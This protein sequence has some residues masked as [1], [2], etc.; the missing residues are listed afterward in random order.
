MPHAFVLMPFDEG[1]TALYTDFI[2]PVLEEKGLTVARADDIES[3]RNILRDVIEGID[4]CDLVVAELTGNNPNVLYELGLAHALRKP[5]LHLTQNIDDVPF[6]LRSYRMI[7]Y[8][9]DFS[10]IGEAKE[11]LG[12]NARAF[13]DGRSSFGNPVTDF[14]VAPASRSVERD[15]TSLGTQ[16]SDQRSGEEHH[17]LAGSYREPRDQDVDLGF[18]DFWIAV[19]E[20]YGRAGEVAREVE[21][22]LVGLSDHMQ[23]ATDEFERLNANPNASTP[24]AAI[25]VCRRLAGRFQSFKVEVRKANGIFAETLDNTE[26]SLERLV[27]FQVEQCDSPDVIQELDGLRTIRDTV[28]STYRSVLGFADSMDRLPRVERRP[29]NR[30]VNVTSVD[31][32]VMAGYLDR[33]YGSISRAIRAAENVTDAG[34]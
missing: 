33:I 25:A 1:S 10:K 32:R 30:E 8:S 4:K 22:L 12:S 15:P 13:S 29:L 26:D 3:N 18:L 6:D 34:Q 14:Y 11:K 5:V 24:N 2:R 31:T 20:G 28:Y 23:D 7:E 9:R 16:R 19:N 27:A 17:N 21:G